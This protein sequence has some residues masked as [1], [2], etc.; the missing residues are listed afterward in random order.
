[1]PRNI[2]QI[3]KLD[4]NVVVNV[5]RMHLPLAVKQRLQHGNGIAFI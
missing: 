2:K 4:C 5:K 3:C 1:M